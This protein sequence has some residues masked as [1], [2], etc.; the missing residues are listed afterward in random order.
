MTI[1]A[2]AYAQT[3]IDDPLHLCNVG[4]ASCGT[5]N[6][7]TPDTGGAFGVTSSPAPQLGALT[8][9]ILVPINDTETFG[10]TP[11]TG[12]MNGSA[13]GFGAVT[14]RGTFGSGFDLGTLFGGT[15]PPNP[16]DA[17]FAASA[18]LDPAFSD[19]YNVFTISVIGSLT[20]GALTGLVET[21]QQGQVPPDNSFSFV[22]DTFTVQGQ[23][24]TS[25]GLPNGTIVTAFLDEIGV[26]APEGSGLHETDGWVSTAQSS[27]LVVDGTPFAAVPEP[28][29]WAMM[30]A[31][32]GLLGFAAMRK[33][34]R[35]PRLAV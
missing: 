13:T 2:P 26:V 16:L 10:G 12:S 18:A 27:A 28:S 19:Q 33:G 23:S 29:T 5:F 1:G 14:L 7:V 24:G 8:F 35:E 20:N 21:D 4:V 9:A 31:G 30:L 15:T 25:D 17:Y 22:N 34:K 6:G 3:V 32:F 11:M